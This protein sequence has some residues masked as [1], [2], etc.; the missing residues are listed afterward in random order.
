LTLRATL[1]GTRKGGLAADFPGSCSWSASMLD[2]T[3]LEGVSSGPNIAGRI[4][5][6]SDPAELCV[7]LE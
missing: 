6:L 3:F 2:S 7:D 5:A 4:G 1:R